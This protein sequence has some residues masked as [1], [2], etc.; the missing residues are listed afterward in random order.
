MNSCRRI[1]NGTL[2]PILGLVLVTLLGVPADAETLLAQ[3]YHSHLRSDDVGTVFFNFLWRVSASPERKA[4]ISRMPTSADV[5]QT[6]P[7]D[8]AT[9][10][11]FHEML[12]GPSPG[13][14]IVSS[15]AP[16]MF[17]EAGVG[18]FFDGPFMGEFPTEPVP[19]NIL[20]MKEFIAEPGFQGYYRITGVHQ[21][22]E[23]A[24]A[25]P[26]PGFP[27]ERRLYWGAQ[28]IRIYGERIPEPSTCLLVGICLA[29]LPSRRRGTNNRSIA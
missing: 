20:I 27:P 29:M 13:G 1:I 23:A 10:A 24:S 15:F 2:P 18:D 6:F 26:I 4:E 3:F 25:E 7:A 5:G 14:G 28:T 11:M 16:L 22:I 17:R 21:T 9:V 19:E 8:A 12:A